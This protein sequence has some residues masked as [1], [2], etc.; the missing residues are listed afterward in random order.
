MLLR[1]KRSTA[2]RKENMQIHAI[3]DN[4]GKTLDRFTILTEPWY[5][6]KSCDALCV[7]NNPTHPQYG[8]SQWS[9]AYE[10]K[11]LGRKISFAQL[12]KNVQ[13]HILERL[14]DEG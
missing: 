10:G 13:D 9:E 1:G 12:P 2:Y 3:Y 11:H 8:V 4:D 5:F 7:S 14:S 6:G